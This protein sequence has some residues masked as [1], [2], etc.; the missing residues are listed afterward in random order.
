MPAEITKSGSDGNASTTEERSRRRSE[1]VVLRV[2][3]ELTAMMHHG[4][5]ISIQAHTLVVNAHGGL[6]DV[7]IEM[8]RGQRIRLNNLKT[9]IV[10]SGRILR[11]E[12]SEQG[13]FSVAF[14]FESP[15][16]HFWPI[17][18]P[19]TDWSSPAGKAD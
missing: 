19:P 5:R 4:A 11:V 6:L 17:T 10:A 1:R 3:V 15:A 13:R 7:G 8:V 2:P 14:E 9:E 18:F 12:A 16:P